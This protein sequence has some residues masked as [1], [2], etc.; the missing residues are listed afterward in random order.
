MT[1]YM[2]FLCKWIALC[3]VEVLTS[4]GENNVKE[5]FTDEQ[6]KMMGGTRRTRWPA[7]LLG[8]STL[9]PVPCSFSEAP[10]QSEALSSHKYDSLNNVL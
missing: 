7:H 3:F 1:T 6:S 8:A 5:I 10:H 9:K 2:I 4:S